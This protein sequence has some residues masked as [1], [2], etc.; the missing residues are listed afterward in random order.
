MWAFFLVLRTR[1]FAKNKNAYKFVELG[2]YESYFFK[3]ISRNQLLN[4]VK[5]DKIR[6]I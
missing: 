3:N 2:N 4:R 1:S 5:I 6:N